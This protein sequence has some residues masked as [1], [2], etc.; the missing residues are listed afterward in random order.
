[1]N[2]LTSTLIDVFLL[3]SPTLPCPN[4]WTKLYPALDFVVCGLAVFEFL[5]QIFSR[6]F[7]ALHFDGEDPG[8]VVDPTL[9]QALA[10]SAVNGSRRRTSQ[11][12]LANP[13]TLPQVMSLALCLEPVRYLMNFWPSGLKPSSASSVPIL[14]EIL[15]ASTSPV[16]ASLQYLAALLA[17]EEDDDS[18]RLRLL[19]QTQGFDSLAAFQAQAPEQI[20]KLRSALYLTSAWVYRR[21]YHYFQEHDALSLCMLADES[22]DAGAVQH[23]LERWDAKAPCCV[24][25]G[26]PRFLKAKGITAEDLQTDKWRQLLKGMAMMLQLTI[27]DVECRHARNNHNKD[28]LFATLVAK[29]INREAK[30]CAEEA[31]AEADLKLSKKGLAG[32]RTGTAHFGSAGQALEVR[33]CERQ[34]QKKPGCK[35]QSALELFRQDLL[36]AEQRLQT[37]VNPVSKE[38]WAV[39]RSQ[40]L[41]KNSSKF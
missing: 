18:G 28:K 25:A 12:F 32:A 24:S 35:A 34:Q 36:A 38:H 6:A 9:Q 14:L 20:R 22:A 23:L 8:Q 10:W 31:F 7:D 19:W 40:Q 37:H 3:A 29:Y 41:G 2:K 39:V 21:H 4:K 15:N 5:P 13:S 1:V 17:R 27:A 11:D 16:V 30:L 33:G 26:L